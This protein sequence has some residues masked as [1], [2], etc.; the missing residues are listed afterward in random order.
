[1]KNLHITHPE[2]LT[3]DGKESVQNVIEVM[4]S[5]FNDYNQ[6]RNSITVKYDGAPSIVFGTDVT[7]KRFFV[8]TKSVF[9]KGIKKICYTNDCIDYYYSEKTDLRNILRLCLKYLPR[10]AGVYQ[11]DFIGQG[12]GNTTTFTP[13]TITYKFDNA[14]T[15][16]IIMAVHTCYVGSN[17]DDM[18]AVPQ[19]SLT[20]PGLNV[21]WVDAT[22]S[23][24]EEA[25]FEQ[26][27]EYSMDAI[28][29][30]LELM[31]DDEFPVFKT[32][33]AKTRLM[34]L[35]NSYIRDGRILNAEDL[36]KETGINMR[37][38]ELWELIANAKLVLLNR[39][40]SNPDVQCFMNNKECNH[41]G[42]VVTNIAHVMMI[43]L[44][45]RYEFS[46]ANFNNKKFANAV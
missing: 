9:N 16:N 43:K 12:D 37:V 39:F 32:K 20:M 33:I 34:K 11:A 45:D 26:A 30:Q 46:R 4:R 7:N 24:N 17:F 35:I 13:N 38:F 10:V 23:I 29:D 3:F 41:E 14:P 40:L 22:V 44:I 1:M 42:I 27:F 15:E 31:N 2:D 28:V 18:I 8:G 21:K 19:S 25:I 36:S 5:A 6:E